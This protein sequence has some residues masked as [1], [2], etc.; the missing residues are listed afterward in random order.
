MS[1]FAGKL[2]F[3]IFLKRDKIDMQTANFLAHRSQLLQISFR[4][5]H[6]I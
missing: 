1:I 6:K 3:D 4:Y 5:K 2:I